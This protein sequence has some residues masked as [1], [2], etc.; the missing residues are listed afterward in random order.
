M[1]ERWGDEDEED[2]KVGGRER[3]MEG[4]GG[5]GTTNTQFINNPVRALHPVGVKIIIIT[6]K[7]LRV[8]LGM[9]LIVQLRGYKPP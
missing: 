2:R 1:W 3:E 8:G 4:G 5:E 6:M 9:Q 7:V